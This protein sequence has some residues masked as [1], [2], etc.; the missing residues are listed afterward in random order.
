MINKIFTVYFTVK[1]FQLLLTQNIMD[2]S[3]KFLYT[4]HIIFISKQFSDR[5]HKSDIIPKA[6]IIKSDVFH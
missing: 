2:G 6:K 3:Q 5:S 1:E 4:L